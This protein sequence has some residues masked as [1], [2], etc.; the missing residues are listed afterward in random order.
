MPLTQT[1]L[2]QFQRDGFIIVDG[3]FD[4]KEVEAALAEMASK[5]LRQKF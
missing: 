2:N 5:L 4:T 3:V 1:Q